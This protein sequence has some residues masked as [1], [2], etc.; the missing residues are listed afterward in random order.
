MEERIQALETELSQIKERNIRVERNKDWETSLTRKVSIAFLTY[1]T[2]VL[3]M[4]ATGSVNPYINAIIPTLG[5]FIST[6][7]LPV[8]RRSWERKR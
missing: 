6:L 3:V 4:A 5:F 8:I 1:L 2:M 7:S